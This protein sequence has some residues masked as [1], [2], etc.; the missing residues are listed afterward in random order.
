MKNNLNQLY[1]WLTYPDLKLSVELDKADLSKSNF[2][3]AE[4]EIREEINTLEKKYQEFQREVRLKAFGDE[5]GT[6]K[7]N[8][9]VTDT[10]KEYTSA[11]SALVKRL[12][13]LNHFQE[14]CQTT[15]TV[16]KANEGAFF[17]LLYYL[18]QYPDRY[19]RSEEVRFKYRVAALVPFLLASKD[20]EA[21]ISLFNKNESYFI[22][23]PAVKS[24]INHSINTKENKV[25][26]VNPEDI[27]K[28]IEAFKEHLSLEKNL[29]GLSPLFHKYHGNTT[30]FAALILYL[31]EQG[32]SSS[33]LIK[34]RILDDFIASH[35]LE[36][37]EPNNEVR[38]LYKILDSDESHRANHLIEEAQ[39]TL[40]NIQRV[41]DEKISSINK[42]GKFLLTGERLNEES[43]QKRE[44]KGLSFENPKRID[45]LELNITRDEANYKK[46]YQFYGTDFLI[47]L[48]DFLASELS[49]K[50]PLKSWLIGQLKKVLSEEL[51]ILEVRQ[52][53]HSAAASGDEAWLE[54]FSE[55]FDYKTIEK[56]I[57]S[58]DY[59]ILYIAPYSPRV[60]IELSALTTDELKNYF[61]I[62]PQS[63][64]SFE[65][66]A[67][68]ARV[69]GGMIQHNYFF[70]DEVEQEIC[71][72][73]IHLMISE[74]MV[75]DDELIHYLA[76]S[77]FKKYLDFAKDI[78][79]QYENELKQAIEL[80]DLKKDYKYIEDRW[81]AARRTIDFLKSIVPQDESY[82]KDKYDL[83][84][85]IVKT[86]LEKKDVGFDLEEFLSAVDS[87]ALSEQGVTEYERTLIEIL[88]AIDHGALRNTGMDLLKKMDC[89]D[90][91]TKIY[92]M[93][94]VLSR[95]VLQNNVGL[96]QFLCTTEDYVLNANGVYQALITAIDQNNLGMAQLICDMKSKNKLNFSQILPLYI[97]ANRSTL[98]YPIYGDKYPFVKLMCEVKGEN[99]PDSR[100]ISDVLELSFEAQKEEVFS[101]LCEMK[102]ENKP[103]KR[104]VASV[105]QK[106]VDRNSIKFVDI[107]CKM[108]G[109]NCLTQTM[110]NEALLKAYDEKQWKMAK[111]F[112]GMT[113]DNKPSKDI[114]SKVLEHS[115]M[116]AN[117]LEFVTSLCKISGENC[118]SQSS[119]DV[120]L[121]TACEQKKWDMVKIFFE[122]TGDNKPSKR[123]TEITAAKVAAAGNVPLLN[124]IC[125]AVEGVD[126]RE[127]SKLISG[128][129]KVCTDSA[130]KSK[131]HW[132]MVR[133]LVG[134]TGDNKPDQKIIDDA[135]KLAAQ[136]GHNEI[137]KDYEQRL[138]L[139]KSAEILTKGGF[140]AD[141]KPEIKK[142]GQPDQLTPEQ[143]A[144]LKSL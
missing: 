48:L 85:F 50:T 47:A 103:N 109:E 41:T 28:F 125:N 93:Q 66:V 12:N 132:G 19:E 24:A 38:R 129:L 80:M 43:I 26:K 46:L 21:F 117:Q 9:S 75:Q 134:I 31:L 77:R 118:P 136:N 68:F 15:I 1:S 90:W 55:L 105:F 16:S 142:Q 10:E 61:N 49:S 13:F 74:P 30:Q 128:L 17:I 23:L 100:T 27:K 87:T 57:K 14:F 44:E 130:V 22:A 72:S 111:I 67:L 36:L 104:S 91:A 95:A 73:L 53:L 32:V 62:L 25:E 52:L 137:C 144:K 120:S 40:V 3:D 139:A 84:V 58:G 6:Q 5:T 8:S 106:A 126:N 133:L 89:N 138:L 140:F 143:I 101:I 2:D 34:H 123:Q 116:Y 4:N 94:N 127:H 79:S 51:S 65:S 20:R 81:L 54:V 59:S 29:L 69:L 39:Y 42:V 114:V 97:D 92:G 71:K 76:K 56:F 64:D 70:P 115:V 86:Y 98:F 119:I 18:I 121:A 35:Y 7:E 99:Q 60:F 141:R 107:L 63:H 124:F 11:R 83:R 88:A 96:M 45:K 108:T 102:E 110:I 112:I 135:L 78:V 37:S 33:E 131:Q 82:P 122:M 113:G